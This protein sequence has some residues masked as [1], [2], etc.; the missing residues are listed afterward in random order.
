MPQSQLEATFALQL[1]TS[2]LPEPERE[3]HFA[4]VAV[5]DSPHPPPARPGIRKRLA[6]AGLKDWRW[7]FAWADATPPLA[8]EIQGGIHTQGAH[9]RGKGYEED[10]AKLNAGM[11][12]GWRVLYFTGDMVNNWS[13]LETVREALR[14]VSDE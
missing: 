3:Y 13:A 14:M 6:D 1:R 11:L 10:C 2:G 8:V 4:R 12:L 5:G 7:D 9:T